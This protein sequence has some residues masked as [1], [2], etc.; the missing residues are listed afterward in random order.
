V[1][2]QIESYSPIRHL[3]SI[4]WPP[5]FDRDKAIFAMLTFAFDAGGDAGTDYMTVAGFA[6]SMKDW[7]EFSSKW[8]ARLDKDGI[9]FFRAVDVNNFRGPF[10]HWHDL[11][12]REQLR[13]ALFS[14]LMDLIRR[15]AYR[16]FSCTIINKE[17]QNASSEFREKFAESAYSVAA[18]TCEKYARH[19][20]KAEWKSSP[21]MEIAS[22]F[23][24]GDVGQAKLQERLRK[25]YG[26]LPPNF[27][28]KK[29]TVREDGAIVRGFIPL[30]AA[31][32]LAWELNRAARDCSVEPKLESELRW[33]MQ[34]FLGRPDGYL[35][36]FTPENLKAMED[37]VAL[38]SK[39]VSW[40]TTLGLGKK[41]HSA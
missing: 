40:E 37:M 26:H 12:N 22:I 27:H 15:H 30:Q 29:D 36:I 31:D 2:A 41:K 8:K 1:E 17:F 21:E 19:W 33:P 4:I 6:S 32:W 5:W 3:A 38:Q 13:R 9:E 39:I 23:E 24:A 16:K 18:R 14:D 11:P 20:A 28:P 7:D 25:D 34:Q 35:G 10:E